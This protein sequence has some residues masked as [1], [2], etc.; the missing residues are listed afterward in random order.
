MLVGCLR[1]TSLLRL[2]TPVRLRSVFPSH[3]SLTD[4]ASRTSHLYRGSKT[5]ETQLIDILLVVSVLIRC[6]RAFTFSRIALSMD[7]DR[8]K[9]LFK[10]DRSLMERLADNGFPTSQINV[11]HRMRP[12]ISH[13]IRYGLLPARE[14]PSPT[15]PFTERSCTR[16]WRIIRS[17]SATRM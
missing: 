16:S 9:E 17:S 7:S 14:T 13:N 8:G 11:Q 12:T 5:A 4:K 3:K 2:R 10:F 1:H 6:L 15:F